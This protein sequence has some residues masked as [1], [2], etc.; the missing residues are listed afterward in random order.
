MWRQIIREGAPAGS[1]PAIQAAIAEANSQLPHTLPRLASTTVRASAEYRDIEVLVDGVAVRPE[2]LGASQVIDPGEHHIEAQAPGYAHFSKS[3][4]VGE[5]QSADIVITMT[6]AEGGAEGG[7][8]TGP[9]GEREKPGKKGSGLTTAGFAVGAAGVI[10]MVAGT[11]TLLTRN[12]KREALASKCP[13]EECPIGSITQPELDDEKQSVETLTTMTNV[14]M[15]GGGALI[16]GGVTLIV[17]G[18]S[19]KGDEPKTALTFG[20]PRADFGLSIRGTY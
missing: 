5:G 19:S 18:S 20:S 11:V 15:F 14:L 9:A 6:P 12:N 3:W 10:A 1:S 17:I 8:T 7:P 2:L 16:A 4:T 13:N